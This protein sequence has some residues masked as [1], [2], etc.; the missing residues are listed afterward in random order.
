MTR[1]LT[2]D[3]ILMPP[4]WSDIKSRKDCD[5]TSRFSRNIPL[6][7][8]IAS[9]NMRT[10][11][12]ACMCDAMSEAGG[13]GI[14]HRYFPDRT[15]WI[16]EIKKIAPKTLWGISFGLNTPVDFISRI[17]ELVHSGVL[18][19]YP[20]VIVV[21]VANAE[22]E[23]VFNYVKNLIDWLNDD[24]LRKT[25]DIVIGNIATAEA[26]RRYKMLDIDGLKVGVGPGAACTTRIMTGC[27]VPQFTA[28]QEISRVLKHSDITLIADGGIQQPGH[29]AIALA[30][31]ADCVMMGKVLSMA[32]EAPGWDHWEKVY[33]GEASFRE[34]RSPE[35]VKQIIKVSEPPEPVSLIMYRYKDYIQSSMSYQNAK[36]IHHFQENATFL[37]VSTNTLIE[38][39]PRV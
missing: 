31:G 1:G 2:F 4:K 22:N 14:L 34:D 20:K 9:A 28:I 6:A 13:I 12:D 27:G 10:V 21:D 3:D 25:V 39:K 7:I 33:Q 38:N 35:G 5:T 8:P 29:A 32:K 17:E 36:T 16:S 11:T 24:G 23:H 30:A 37:E 19:T 18:P 26:A 15:G